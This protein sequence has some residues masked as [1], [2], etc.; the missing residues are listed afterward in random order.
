M[1]QFPIVLA[2]LLSILVL[3]CG[4]DAQPTTHN[5]S[6][7]VDKT[8]GS[9][10]THSAYFALKTLKKTPLYDGM[11]LRL[12][13]I[14]DTRYNQTQRFVMDTGATGWL[15]NDHQRRTARRV[16]LKHFKDSLDVLNNRQ[17]SYTRSEVFRLVVSELNVLASATGNRKLVLISDLKE[18]SSFF[19]VYTPNQLRLLNRNLEGATSL[20]EANASLVEDLSGITV[21]IIYQP[22]LK[23]DALFARLV[24]LYQSILEPRGAIV[25]VGNQNTINL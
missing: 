6:M 16:L 17:Q 14:S 9:Q 3:G 21:E 18:N 19:S 13:T 4:S 5:L 24:L 11:N 20:F 12:T 8:E 22:T 25:R 10:V 1:K 7:V 23:D 2:S 15:A